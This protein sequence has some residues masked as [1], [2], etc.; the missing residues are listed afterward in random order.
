MYDVGDEVEVP[1]EEVSPGSVA[2][3]KFFKGGVVRQFYEIDQYAADLVFQTA[4]KKYSGQLG[5]ARPRLTVHDIQPRDASNYTCQ[6]LT[7]TGLTLSKSTSIHIKR[8][9][10]KMNIEITGHF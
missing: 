6:I 2:S 7:N 9:F 5:L 3:V 10:L 4:S 8:N 1:C